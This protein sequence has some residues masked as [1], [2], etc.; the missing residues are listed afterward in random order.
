MMFSAM[1][2]IGPGPGG[3]ALKTEASPASA[4]HPSAM[5]AHSAA[6]AVASHPI[7]AAAV[8][9]AAAQR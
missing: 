4:W 8:A 1:N 5:H 7:S 6:A 3:L 2:A 9:A